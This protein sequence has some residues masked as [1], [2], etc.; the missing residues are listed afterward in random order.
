[1][2][3]K[4][5]ICIIHFRRSSAILQILAFIDPFFVIQKAVHAI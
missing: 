5:A 4:Q 1:M 3:E 2:R